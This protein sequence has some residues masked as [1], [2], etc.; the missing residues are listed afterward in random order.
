MQFRYP[1]YGNY[2]LQ[3]STSLLV[4]SKFTA[5]S[6]ESYTNSSSTTTPNYTTEK[7]HETQTGVG[8]TLLS[9]MGYGG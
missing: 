3:V 9:D 8:Y 5:G 7:I 1:Q 4:L 6:E 2:H